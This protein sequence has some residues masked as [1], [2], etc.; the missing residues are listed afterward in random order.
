MFVFIRIF[1]HRLLLLW[2]FDARALEE[3]R[4]IIQST[5]LMLELSLCFENAEIN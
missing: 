5:H 4:K 1:I 3:R 2:P